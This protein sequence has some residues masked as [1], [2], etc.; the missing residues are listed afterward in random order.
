MRFSQY[1]CFKVL[2]P[3]MHINI[4]GFLVKAGY[5]AVVIRV[6]IIKVKNANIVLL[7]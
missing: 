2:D 4:N 3:L 6:F 1:K 5:Y 7:V